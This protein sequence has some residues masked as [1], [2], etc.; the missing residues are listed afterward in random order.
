MKLHLK[1]KENLISFW[2]SIKRSDFNF[3][4]L[5][6]RFIRAVKLQPQVFRQV[7]F[8]ERALAQAILVVFLSSIAA[9]IGVLTIGGISGML[10]EIMAALIVWS[11]WTSLIFFIASK[12]L[13]PLDSRPD[14]GLV[15]RS[16]GF[17]AAP[18]SLRILG[19]IP[20]LTTFVFFAASAWMLTAMVIAVKATFDYQKLWKPLAVC[21]ISWLLQLTL[22]GLPLYLLVQ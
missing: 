1:L 20:H 21:L 5:N 4:V 7:A 9:G 6:A 17:S 13:P 12:I 3:K 2:S 16:L 10:F 11:V 22:I 8:D 19:V 14:L 18:G 15:F